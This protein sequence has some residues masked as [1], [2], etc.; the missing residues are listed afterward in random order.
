[1]VTAKYEPNAHACLAHVG[2]EV[3]AVFGWR[4]GPAKGETLA[5]ERADV[6]V[7]DTTH[8]VSA[9]RSGAIGR[10]RGRQWSARCIGAE[11]G[12]SRRRARLA[13]RLRGLAQRLGFQPVT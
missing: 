4:F 5:A 3:D 13:R 1:M 12:G 2:L 11:R 8:D 9:A 10:G 7:G 6:Y